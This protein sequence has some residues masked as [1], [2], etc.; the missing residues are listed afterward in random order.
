M[1]TVAKEEFSDLKKQQESFKL[2]RQSFQTGFR[3]R[4]TKKMK[5]EKTP[6]SKL[7]LNK[8]TKS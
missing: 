6:M 5:R 4:K 3:N 7:Q 8:I 2:Q 1:K